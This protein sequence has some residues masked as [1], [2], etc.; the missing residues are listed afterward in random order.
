MLMYLQQLLC[1]ISYGTTAYLK[2]RDRK[3]NTKAR[4]LLSSQLI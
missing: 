2:L 3:N 1:T 4:H